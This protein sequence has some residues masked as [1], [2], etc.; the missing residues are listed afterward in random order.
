MYSKTDFLRFCELW[1]TKTPKWLRFDL[2]HLCAP[3][4]PWRIGL[5]SCVVH[6]YNL[7]GCLLSH[8]HIPK[9]PRR[10]AVGL[11]ANRK[12]G[13]FS[14]LVAH[15]SQYPRY[16]FETTFIGCST[17]RSICLPSLSFIGLILIN[18]L[19]GEC[20]PN[21]WC[22]EPAPNYIY[23]TDWSLRVVYSHLGE[24]FNAV[25]AYVL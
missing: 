16:Y 21:Q 11:G 4:S 19:Q 24:H 25:Y 18:I 2:T 15:N 10:G 20:W 1:A 22:A 5:I 17:S 6:L 13:T 3:H 9:P 12:L 8:F 7:H 14:V 23:W